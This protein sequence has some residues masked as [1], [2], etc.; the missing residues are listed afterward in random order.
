MGEDHDRGV[1][2]IRPDLLGDLLDELVL[3]L[4]EVWPAVGTMADRVVRPT[5]SSAHQ[6]W[7]RS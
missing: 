2:F 7:D 1:W 5:R 6:R 4:E 3:S